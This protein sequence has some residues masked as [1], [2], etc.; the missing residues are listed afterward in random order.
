VTDAQFHRS[1]STA[2]DRRLLIGSSSLIWQ[3]W[4]T[5]LRAGIQPLKTTINSTAA[6]LSTIALYRI[7]VEENIEL[8]HTCRIRGPNGAIYAITSAIG[9]ER[10]GEM[11]MIEAEIRSQAGLFQFARR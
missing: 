5:G 3:T 6:T 1:V 2:I 4:K 8:N 9:A 10:S 11:Q 7:F